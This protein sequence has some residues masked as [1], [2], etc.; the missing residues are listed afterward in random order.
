M[1]LSLT[2]TQ[3]PALSSACLLEARLWAPTAA[4]SA[5]S[6]KLKARQLPQPPLQHKAQPSSRKLCAWERV[7]WLACWHLLAPASNLLLTPPPPPAAAAAAAVLPTTAL[8][9]EGL[10][11]N[12]RPEPFATLQIEIQ[13]LQLSLFTLVVLGATNRTA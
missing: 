2:R 8:D 11:G 12:K 6:E 1:P 10:K 5:Q 4:Q 13:L 7:P 3:C 9:L